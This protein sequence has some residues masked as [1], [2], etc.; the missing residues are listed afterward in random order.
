MVSCK[1]VIYIWNAYLWRAEVRRKSILTPHEA[2]NT[3]AKVTWATRED[4]N[5]VLRMD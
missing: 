4:E 3:R 1:L 2:G 5:K